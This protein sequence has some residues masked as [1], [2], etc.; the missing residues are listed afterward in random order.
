[1]TL[2][3]S[4]LSERSSNKAALCKAFKSW[5]RGLVGVGGAAALR[6]PR[7]ASEKGSASLGAGAFAPGPPAFR[8]AEEVITL[9]T[10][11]RQTVGASVW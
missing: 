11:G 9:P 10:L 5:I 8:V 7:G 2:L 4:L 1:M 3:T 6:R